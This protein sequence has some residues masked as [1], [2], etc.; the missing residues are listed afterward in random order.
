M[1]VIPKRTVPARIS[2]QKRTNANR[3]SLSLDVILSI[4]KTMLILSKLPRLPMSQ[5]PANFS[6]NAIQ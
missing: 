3:F 2:G 5:S 4:L 1:D 6:L